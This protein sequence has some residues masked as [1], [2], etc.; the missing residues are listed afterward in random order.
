MAILD[1]FNTRTD[2]ASQAEIRQAAQAKYSSRKENFADAR[3]LLIFAGSEQKTWLMATQG[4]LYLI[5]DSLKDARPEAIWRL[6]RSLLMQGNRVEPELR[7]TRHTDRTGKL[8]VAG[9]APRSF[10]LDLFTDIPID[11]RLRAL[12]ETAFT[13]PTVTP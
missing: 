7:V 1:I 3:L 8:E 12:L 4:G 2:F 9:K 10:T 6:D 5:I 13:D 11:R